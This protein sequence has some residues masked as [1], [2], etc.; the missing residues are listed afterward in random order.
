MSL[1]TKK[2]RQRE[3]QPSNVF[4]MLTAYQIK[5]LKSVYTMIDETNDDII[6]KNDLNNFLPRILGDKTDDFKH[7]EC[8]INFY[9]LLSLL[10]DHFINLQTKEKMNNQIRK[11]GMGKTV[12]KKELIHHL[13]NSKK[14]VGQDKLTE[15]DLNYILNVFENDTIRIEALTNL[16]RHGEILPNGDEQ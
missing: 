8:D 13:L 11:F 4:N 9:S 6:C 2:Q 15:E 7:I 3:R 14:N 10:S 12:S 1:F 16:L 5:S